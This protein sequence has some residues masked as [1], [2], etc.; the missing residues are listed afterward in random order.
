MNIQHILIDDSNPEH[1]ELSIYR[2][3]KINRV[4]L[5]DKTYKTYC[6][7]EIEAH[8]YAAFFHYGIAEAL[9][10]LPFLSESNNGL[11]SWDEA[12]LHN[13]S[14]SSMNR[15]IDE[16]ITSINL[17]KKEIILLGWQD[18]PVGVAYLREIDPARFLDFIKILKLFVA[19]SEVQRCD[20]EFIL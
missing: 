10:K 3:G 14:L 7:L 18:E 15:I 16:R 11:D 20:L 8:N 4:R 13:S 17:E 6:S 1:Y 12:F 5:L 9:N 19:E 2:T